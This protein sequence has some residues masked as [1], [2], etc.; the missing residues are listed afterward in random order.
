MLRLKP[1]QSLD[2]A[3]TTIRAL[4]PEILGPARVPQFLEEPFTL[5]PA[6]AGTD[7]PASAGRD[8]NARS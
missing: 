8:T 7:I 5:V 4:Q 2:A 1:G 3:T 6:A